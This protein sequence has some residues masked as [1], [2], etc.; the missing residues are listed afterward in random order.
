LRI[1]QSLDKCQ[2]IETEEGFEMIYTK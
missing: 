2:F 1:F